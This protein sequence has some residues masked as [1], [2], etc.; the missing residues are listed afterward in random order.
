MSPFHKRMAARNKLGTIS[1]RGSL[2][3]VGKYIFCT[4]A[5]SI[6][7]TLPANASFE[8]H[9][10]SKSSKLKNAFERDCV[11]HSPYA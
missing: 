9:N 1:F 8:L 10:T 7:L 3:P 2:E 6:D 5:G 4:K 11:G